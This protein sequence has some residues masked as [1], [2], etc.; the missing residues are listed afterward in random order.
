MR[1]TQVFSYPSGFAGSAGAINVVPNYGG[2]SGSTIVLIKANSGHSAGGA[3]YTTKQPINN[4]FQTDFTFQIVGADAT[5]GGAPITSGMTFIVQDDPR[6]DGI[7]GDANGWGYAAYE[8]YAG[9]IPINNSIAVKFDIG[10]GYYVNSPTGYSNTTGLYLNGGFANASLPAQ[11]LSPFGININSGDI[12]AVT[13]VYDGAILTMTMRDTVTN[14][15]GR[16]SWPVDIPTFTGSNTAWVGF[17]AGN[18]SNTAVDLLSWDFYTG[19][20]TR[21]AAPTFS[22]KP[23]KYTTAQ[24]V[25]LSGPPGAKIYYT[26]NGLVPTSSSTPYTGAAISITSN[27]FLQAVAIEDGYTDSFVAQGNYNVQGNGQPTINFPS[28]FASAASLISIVGRASTSAS[29]LRLTDGSNPPT[30]GETGAAWYAAPVS[31]ANFTT[32]FQINLNAGNARG[33]AFVIQNQPPAS[34]GNAV[35]G[36][37]GGPFAL[38]N[39]SMGMG[40]GGNGITNA[41]GNLT[42]AETLGLA[43]SVAVIFAPINGS[44]SYTGLFTNGVVPTTAAAVDMSGSLNLQSGHSMN[45]QLTYDGTMLTVSVTDAVTA[46][47]FTKSFPVDIPT[48]VGAPTAFV[49]FT[50]GDYGGSAQ[51]V[52]S[53]TGF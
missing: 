5:A 20:N 15:Q 26:T 21:L 53:W 30:Q 24:S 41:G 51:Q 9:N 39:G 14:A 17:G 40:F 44:G 23:G 32:S 29:S 3:W 28:G 33:M 18:V 1:A 8:E 38:S 22:V 11:D 37:T 4:G 34:A 47:N 36:V 42:T 7:S 50:G 16:Y 25:S 43:N 2:L 45:V 31:I 12:M 13:L 27:T 49:G 10:G 35:S 19:Y 48:V 46:A 6:G 52:N